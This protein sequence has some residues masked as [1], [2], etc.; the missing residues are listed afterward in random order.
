MAIKKR[1]IEHSINNIEKIILPPNL[2]VKIP[3]GRRNIDPDKM[4]IPSNQPTS[5]TDQL[6]KPLS[7]K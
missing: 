1:G 3:I 4:G 2:S 7:T 5:T 6:K